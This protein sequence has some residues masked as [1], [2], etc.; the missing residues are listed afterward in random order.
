MKI[1]SVTLQNFRQHRKLRIDLDTSQSSFTVIRGR[2]GAGKTNLLKSITWVLTGRLAKDE[3]RFDQ[4]SLVSWSTFKNAKVGEK[5]EVSVKID[6]DLGDLGSAQVERTARFVKTGIEIKDISYSGSEFSVLSL[7]DKAKG[8]Q[9]EPDPDLWVET[10]FPDRFSHYF[11][12]DGE[13]LHRFFKETE[14]AYVKRAV[15]EIANID[16]LE[17]IVDHLT[18]VLQGLVKDAGVVAGGK[19]I[20]LKDDYEF[21]EQQISKLNVELDDKIKL[22]EGLDSEL[23]KVSQQMGDITAIKK[24]MAQRNQLEEIANAAS[25]RKIEAENE[26]HQWAFKVGPALILAVQVKNLQEEIEKAKKQK[27]LPPPYKPEALQELIK[28]G[29]CICGRELVAD[30]APC[31]S[32]AAMLDKFT[33]LSE[34]GE[35]LSE[36]QQ[37]IH[38]LHARI[39]AS[40]NTINSVQERI[41][42]AIVDEQK[43]MKDLDIIRHKLLGNDDSKINFISN[44]YEIV[45]KNLEDTIQ[46]IG[47]LQGQLDMKKVELERI[48][49][50]IEAEAATIEKAQVA[51]RRQKFAEAVLD[52]AKTLYESF[53]N[54]VR[55]S[56]AKNLNEE[57]QSMIWKKNFFKPVEIDEDY[58][59]LVQNNLG[60]ESRSHLS[61]GETACLAFAFSITLS[62]VAGFSYPMVVDSPLGRLDTEVKEFVSN[63]LARALKANNESDSKQILMLVLDSEYTKDVADAIAHMKP[64]VMEIIFDQEIA[65]TRLEIVQ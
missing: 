56:V 59:V 46:E 54:Q 2:N 49:K 11:L 65:E 16:Q 63:V 55:E 40:S 22:R 57:F 51:L 3:P 43:A 12:F 25:K 45:K 38:Q 18:N 61:A 15:L 34:I 37:P 44:Q 47:N 60:I 19:G 33:D 31:T 6:L 4:A 20:K 17:K 5:I 62:V 10:V 53:S 24:D 41:K 7:Q 21:T 29:Q 58:K 35:V 30:S 48:H 39:E 8:Y 13:H 50:E 9:K 52:Q 26:L 14:A 32:I 36:L 1:R 23:S 64:K 27:V 28:A 42:T